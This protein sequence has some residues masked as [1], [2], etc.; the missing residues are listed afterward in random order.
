MHL[1]FHM[2]FREEMPLLQPCIYFGIGGKV[3][4]V[5]CP[6]IFP[7][8]VCAHFFLGAVQLAKL[9]LTNSIIF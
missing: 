9:Y 3:E 4:I 7:P 1:L 6:T 2:A 5:F 8:Y